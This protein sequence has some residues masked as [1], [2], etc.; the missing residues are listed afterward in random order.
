MLKPAPLARRSTRGLTLIELMIAIAV[1]GVGVSLATPSF[2]QQIGNYRVRAA[3]ESMLSGLNYAR[4]EAVR[5]NRSVSFTLSASGSGWSVDQVSP[6]LNLQTRADGETAGLT[7]DSS[8]ATR[9]VTFTATGMVDTSGARLAQV[10]LSA[11]AS[12][13]ETRRIDIFGGGLIRMC[14]PAATVA[15]D[16]RRC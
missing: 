13:T 7:V 6:A 2:T 3:A 4:T 5:R 16:P 9:V 8:T 11:P 15:G 14:D 10:N 1:L 12:N